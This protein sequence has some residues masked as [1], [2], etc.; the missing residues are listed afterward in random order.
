MCS[1]AYAD[2]YARHYTQPFD[3]GN[4]HEHANAAH[5]PKPTPQ[6]TTDNCSG[7][8]TGIESPVASV[9][10]RRG[11]NEG[12]FASSVSIV[13][14][15][16]ENGPCFGREVCPNARRGTQLFHGRNAYADAYARH[17]TQP[18]DDSNAHE[19][20]NSSQHKAYTTVHN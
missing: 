2:A 11:P 7:E 10:G 8:F 15:V 9:R 4:A 6:S 18:F 13:V 14:S 3:D 1:N 19:R 16:E 5:N 20:A 17:Y 12:M